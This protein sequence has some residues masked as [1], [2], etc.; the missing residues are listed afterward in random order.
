MV[1]LRLTLTEV[2]GLVGPLEHTKSPT[3]QGSKKSGTLLFEVEIRKE[4]E[5]KQC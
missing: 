2:F 5:N 3:S 4:M 1:G